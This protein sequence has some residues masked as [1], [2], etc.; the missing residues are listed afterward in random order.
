MCVICFP[1]AAAQLNLPFG[2]KDEIEPQDHFC[3]RVPGRFYAKPAVTLFKYEMLMFTDT[4]V[5]VPE[6]PR[7]LAGFDG[8]MLVQKVWKL[9]FD[10][11]VFCVACYCMPWNRVVSVWVVMSH[12]HDFKIFTHRI[13]NVYIQFGF[14]KMFC[15]PSWKN[16]LKNVGLVNYYIVYLPDWWIWHLGKAPTPIRCWYHAEWTQ[17]LTKNRGHNPTRD[18]HGA[19]GIQFYLAICGVLLLN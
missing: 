1:T 7:G 10:S 9:R 5:C 18:A 4:S 15:N 14:V 2:S 6:D 8:F 3:H 11:F 16:G 12:K 13:S 19:T 17:H